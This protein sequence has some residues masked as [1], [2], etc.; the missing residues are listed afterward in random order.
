ME[1]KRIADA[2]YDGIDEEVAVLTRQALEDGHTAEEVLNE[3]L[4]P[5]MDRVANDFEKDVLF[6]PEVLIAADA[7]MAGMDV[8]RPLLSESGSSKMATFI[9]GTVQGDI[10]DIGKNLVCIMLE[11]AGMEV[12]D[13]GKDTPPERFVEAVREHKPQA[14]LMSSLLT[15]TMGEMK[16]VIEA[17]EREGLRDEVKVVIGG[18]PINQEYAD[19]IG[20]DGYAPNAVAAVELTKQLLREWL[21]VSPATRGAS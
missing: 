11:G 17:L 21:E 2:L 14:V 1:W 15:T 4:L 13:L 20:A 7:M 19:R 6:V 10:H 5:G 8:I 16:Q 3:G 9:A 18:A 12:I